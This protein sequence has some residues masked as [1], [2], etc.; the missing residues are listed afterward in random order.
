M[1]SFLFILV[2]K[3]AAIGFI[4]EVFSGAV[5]A[6]LKFRPA[7]TYGDRVIRVREIR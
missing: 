7:E 5:P 1:L 2:P 6:H 3:I 4:S